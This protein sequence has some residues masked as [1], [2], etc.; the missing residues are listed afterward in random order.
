MLALFRRARRAAQN[1]LGSTSRPFQRIYRE[2]L[3]GSA[4]SRSGTGSTSIATAAL[5]EQLPPLL[6]QLGIRT[7]LDAPCGDF[8]VRRANL[9]LDQYIGVDVVPALVDANSRSDGSPARRFELLDLTET[10]PPPVDLILCRDLLIHLSYRHSL[11]VLSNFRQSGSRFLLI[12]QNPDHPENADIVTG[13]FR[14]LNLRLPPFELPSPIL[15]LGDD[16]REPGPSTVRRTMAL[17]RLAD[18]PV[19]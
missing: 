11:R 1:R 5:C 12:S 18:L 13:S 4:E 19:T 8:W 14:P 6:A 15:E 7:M 9:V 2:N 17:W 16:S 3:W 10:V